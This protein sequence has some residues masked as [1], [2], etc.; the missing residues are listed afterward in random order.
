MADR[1]ED[2][3]EHLA[4]DGVQEIALIF[5]RI[6]ALEESPLVSLAIVACGEGVGS[7]CARL[8]EECFEFDFAVAEDIGIGSAALAALVEKVGENVLPIFLNE[9]DRIVGNADLLANGDH[10]LIFARSFADPLAILLFPVFHEEADDAEAL[11]FKQERGHRRIDAAGHADY[12]SFRI[13]GVK[14]QVAGL[15]LEALFPFGAR[16]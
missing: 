13:H 16:D 10:I 2:M 11:L 14:R 7:Q 3:P 8:I 1:K 5:V 12:D 9:V 6:G 15:K 4:L